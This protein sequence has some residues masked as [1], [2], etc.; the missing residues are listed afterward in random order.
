[1]LNTTL[2]CRRRSSMAAAMVVSVKMSPHDATPRLVVQD[3]RAF[4]ISPRDDLEEGCGVFGGHS[5]ITE[6]VDD[7]NTGSGEEPHGGGPASFECGFAAA[8]GEVGCGGV[9]DPVA[10]VDGGVAEGDGEHGFAD[11]GRPDERQRWWRRR[12]S[13][14]S[15]TPGSL[16]RRPRIGRQSRSRRRSMGRGSWRTSSWR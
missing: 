9:V 16:P 12:G 3:D 10:G 14:R 7:E 6:L 2:R 11:A 8:G 13:C 5:Q 4:E 1:M 15:L